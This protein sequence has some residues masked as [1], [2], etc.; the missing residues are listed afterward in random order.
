[1]PHVSGSSGRPWLKG[2]GTRPPDGGALS[3]PSCLWIPEGRLCQRCAR[4]SPSA[5]GDPPTPTPRPT[6]MAAAAAAGPG[7]SLS[8]DELLPKGDAEKPEDE[9]EEEDDD[10]VLSPAGRSGERGCRREAGVRAPRAEGC[11]RRRVEDSGEVRTEAPRGGGV[12][13]R[14]GRG[15]LAP[16]DPCVLGSRGSCSCSA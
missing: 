2:S 15:T 8:P 9:L 12:S 3:E 10:E 7:A 14:W 5:S 4:L 11:G 1:M 16:G 6:A 13:P